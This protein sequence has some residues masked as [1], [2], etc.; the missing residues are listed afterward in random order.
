MPNHVTN[1]LNFDCTE[2]KFMEIANFVK[3]DDGELGS[4][5]F[6][7]ILPMPKELDI[8]SGSLG[9]EGYKMYRQYLEDIEGVRSVK[10][11]DAIRHS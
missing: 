7:K 6:N 4:F 11:R 3:R 8:S 2:E 9:M 1:I 5:D 10:R